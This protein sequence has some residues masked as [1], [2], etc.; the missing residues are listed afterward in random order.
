M[1]TAI[2][3]VETREITV[4]QKDKLKHIVAM[5]NEASEMMV[6]GCRLYVQLIDEC[7]QIKETLLDLGFTNSHL[8]K[9]EGIGRGKL[10]ARLIDRAGKP[11][12]YLM[13]CPLSDQRKYLSGPVEVA[14]L[15]GDV[16]KIDLPSLSK[17]QIEQVFGYDHV[18]TIPEQIA[19]IE[20]KKAVLNVEAKVEAPAYRITKVGLSITKPITLTKS[21]LLHILAEM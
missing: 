19:F 12:Q 7:P 2:T 9:C 1:S 8:N 10:D 13:R 20:K 6:E 16:R 21:E 11:Y 17:D 15:G 4:E 5:W 18:R 3:E 14:L